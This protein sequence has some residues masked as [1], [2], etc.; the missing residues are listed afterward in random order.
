MQLVRDTVY[1]HVY[2]SISTQHHSDENKS[3]NQNNQKNYSLHP[4]L[5]IIIIIAAIVYKRGLTR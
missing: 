2:R 3:P 4:P 5:I 1:L